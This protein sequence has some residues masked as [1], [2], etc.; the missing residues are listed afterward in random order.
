M[1]PSRKSK[2][3]NLPRILFA[4]LPLPVI[5]PILSKV[6]RT[7]SHNRPELTNRLGVHKYKSFVIDPI[8]MPFVLL[9]QPNPDDPSLKAYRRNRLPPFDARIAGTLLTLLDMVDGKL[10]GDA[11]FFTRDLIV[12]GDTEAV[13]CLRNALDDIEGSIANDIADIFKT[14]GRAALAAVRRIK[15]EQQGSYEHDPA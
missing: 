11:L 4:P 2:I 10:D 3:Q 7:I 6:V 9:L 5:E 8:N 12:E 13:V 14:P 15:G 1:N